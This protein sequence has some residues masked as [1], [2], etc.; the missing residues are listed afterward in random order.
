LVAV[1]ALLLAIVSVAVVAATR[2][3]PLAGIKTWAAYY[4]TDREVAAELARFDLVALDPA[5]APL[6]GAVKRH[7]SLVVMYV[8]L[9]EVNT[10]LPAYA[11]IAGA[12][13]VLD[14]NPNW[15][16][17]RM[18]DVRAPAY[19]TWLSSKIVAPILNGPAN[20]LFLDTADTAIELEREH[21]QKFGGMTVALE[22]LLRTFRA[23]YPRALLVLNGGLPLAERSPA[24]VDA[25]AVESVWTDYDFATKRYRPRAAAD[26]RARAA[27]LDR[28]VARGV[29]VLTLE[30]AEPTDR[31]WIETLIR[32]AREHGFVPYVSTI[33]LDRVFTFTLP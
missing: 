12:P 5:G 2:V 6:L 11:E 20:G 3:R 15:P 31:P 29:P 8:S 9:G 21:P 4:G 19:Q 26:A 27:R 13:W 7:G 30:Y 23:T 28:L 17:A 25:V 10:S 22:A 18:L 16:D 24:L 32:R 14:A 1:V 33:G